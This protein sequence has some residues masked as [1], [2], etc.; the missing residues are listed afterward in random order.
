MDFDL[1][2][3]NSHVFYPYV[4]NTIDDKISLINRC[5]GTV[6]STDLTREMLLMHPQ[7]VLEF[8]ENVGQDEKLDQ[9]YNDLFTGMIKE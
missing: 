2:E 8:R 1:Q 4:G 3:N 7:D 5:F 9:M 6:L